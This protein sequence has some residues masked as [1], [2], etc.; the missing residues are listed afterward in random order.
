MIPNINDKMYLKNDKT[1]KSITTTVID[2]WGEN[3]YHSAGFTVQYNL[4]KT[5]KIMYSEYKERDIGKF[6][7]FNK[8]DINKTVK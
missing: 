4:D 5:N 7:F 3:K 1:N 6:I 2:V 8:K